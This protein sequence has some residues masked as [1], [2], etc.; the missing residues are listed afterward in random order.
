MIPH[1]KKNKNVAITIAFFVFVLGGLVHL[2]RLFTHTSIVIGG[3]D[4]PLFL[5]AI[6]FPFAWFMAFWLWLLRESP[7][8]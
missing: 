8:E 3:A 2:V 5:S 1:L 4:V 6:A 7:S